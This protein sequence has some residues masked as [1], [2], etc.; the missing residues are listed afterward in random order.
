MELKIDLGS[1][2]A[3]IAAILSAFVAL[4]EKRKK[5]SD[6]SETTL[7]KSSRH[8]PLSDLERSRLVELWELSNKD[9]DNETD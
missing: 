8:P 2:L 3:G 1:V 5:S 7:S 9:T 4:R 6:E